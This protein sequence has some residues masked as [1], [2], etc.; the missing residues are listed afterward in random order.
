MFAI[1]T[2]MKSK[3]RSRFGRVLTTLIALAVVVI[4][5][6]AGIL[7]ERV[8]FDFERTAMLKRYDQALRQHQEQL[9]QSEK[10]ASGTLIR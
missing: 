7:V 9:M 3:A 10:H 1:I 8:R 5:F 2:A 6:F 4:A